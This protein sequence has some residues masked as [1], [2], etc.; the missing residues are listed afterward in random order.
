MTIE[1]MNIDEPGEVTLTGRQPQAGVPLMMT[2]TDPDGPVALGGLKWQWETSSSMSGPW[3]PVVGDATMAS[4]TPK[5]EDAT[6]QPGCTSG[7]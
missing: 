7:R 1:I 3:I 2:V 4:Y 6:C 5:N